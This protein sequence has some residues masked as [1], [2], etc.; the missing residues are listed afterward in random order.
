M[1]PPADGQDHALAP[2]R[3]AVMLDERADVVRQL[4]HRTCAA[5]LGQIA[6]DRRI[7][8]QRVPERIQ[9]QVADIFFEDRANRRPGPAEQGKKPQVGVRL[10]CID[11]IASSVPFAPIDFGFRSVSLR[12]NCGAGGWVMVL[13]INRRW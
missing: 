10:E 4:H 13:L 11:G 5:K 3:L 2:V 12:W 1:E 9:Q 6:V 7:A 8:Q